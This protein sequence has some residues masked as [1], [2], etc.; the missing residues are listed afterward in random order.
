MGA[1]TLPPA[2]TRA[3]TSQRDV[4]T[5]LPFMERE[6]SNIWT[7]IEEFCLADSGWRFIPMGNRSLMKPP[8]LSAVIGLLFGAWT[9]LG[10]LATSATAA[11]NPASQAMIQS[12][13]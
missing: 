7:R 12:F 8:E 2:G 13:L 4:P 9:G 11:T 1:G 5:R 3:G 10:C 6:T